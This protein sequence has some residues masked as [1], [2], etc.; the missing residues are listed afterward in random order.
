MSKST[1]AGRQQGA[2]AQFGGGRTQARLPKLVLL[3]G[4]HGT[5]AL[6]AE[7]RAALG[8]DIETQAIEYPRERPLDYAELAAF[9]RARLPLGRPFVL[10]GESFSGPVA[11]QLAAQRLQGLRGLVLSTTFAANPRPALARFAKYALALPPQAVPM[12]VTEFFLLGRWATPKL[13]AD[14]TRVLGEVDADVLSARLA[15][16]LTVDVREHLARIAVPTLYLRA[17]ADRLVPAAAAEVIRTGVAHAQV[18]TLEGPHCLL[19][20]IPAQAARVVKEFAG[21]LPAGRM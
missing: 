16:C 11:I 8:N 10:L 12:S 21:K 19:Q 20:A 6:L 1:F 15:A 18:T 7:F 9:A 13:R 4:L 17:G 3:P 2:H 5:E 14:F